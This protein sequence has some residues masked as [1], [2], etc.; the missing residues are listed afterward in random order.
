LKP[1]RLDGGI[2]KQLIVLTLV[3]E[4]PQRSLQVTLARAFTYEP[5]K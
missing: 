1:I 4:Q 2:G 5:F 3:Q